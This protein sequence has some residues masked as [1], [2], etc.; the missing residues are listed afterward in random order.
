MC[1]ST[2]VPRG[3]VLR[4][5]VRRSMRAEFTGPSFT[6]GV[7]EELMI[8]DGETFALANEIDAV[9]EAYDGD[10]EVKPELLQSVLEIATPPCKD[11][12]EAGEHLRRLRREVSDAAARHDLAIG[13]GGTHPFAMWEGQGGLADLRSLQLIGAL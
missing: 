9:I 3:N 6:L 4:R 10:G 2:P 13:S 11:V 5:T 8:L 12:A 7:E 1:A